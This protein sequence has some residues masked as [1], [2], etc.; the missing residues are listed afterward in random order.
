MK[1]DLTALEGNLEACNRADDQRVSFTLT[2]KYRK[3]YAPFLP[4]TQTELH[5]REH[6][7]ERFEKMREQ[8][9]GFFGRKI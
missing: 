1:P 5:C 2:G 9:Y 7:Q 6:K 4:L 8:V 3:N